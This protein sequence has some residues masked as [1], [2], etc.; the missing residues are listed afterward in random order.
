MQKQGFTIVEVVV[1]FLLILGVTF[2]ILPTS[3][4]NTRQARFI[5]KWNEKYSEIEYMFSVISAQQDSE[6]K[7]KFSKAQNNNDRK[8][9][10]L[11]TIKPYMRITTE[12]KPKDYTQKYMNGTPV[13]ACGRYYFN[14]FYNTSSNEIIGLKWITKNCEN[15]TV[16]GLI[17][18]DLNGIDPPNTWGYDIFGVNVFK[19]KI[20]PFGKDIE[21]DVLKSDCSRFG[22]G[23]YCSYYYLMGGK[24][25]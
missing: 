16:C 19:N 25:D 13:C 22:Y 15:G 12:L 10:L 24:F 1:V 4:D 7:E 5:S 3:L 17:S 20:E 11:E 14:S 6:L 23:L 18:I 21:P 9:I 8:K 2:L